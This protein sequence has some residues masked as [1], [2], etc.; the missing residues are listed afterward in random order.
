VAG[1]TVPGKRLVYLGVSAGIGEP[2]GTVGLGA[3]TVRLCI[4]LIELELCAG[5]LGHGAL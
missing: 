3:V 4:A 1:S 2:Y 5:A